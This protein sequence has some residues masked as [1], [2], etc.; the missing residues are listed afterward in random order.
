VFE[1]ILLPDARAE[2]DALKDAERAQVNM[3]IRLLELDPW[4]DGETKFTTTMENWVAGVYDDGRWE[5]VYRILDSR[6]IEIIGF[7]R[8]NS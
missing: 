4:G 3:I 8:I 7:R 2:R 5:L 1:S 6:F